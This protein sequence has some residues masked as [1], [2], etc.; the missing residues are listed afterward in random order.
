MPASSVF[1]VCVLAVS[2]SPGSAGAGEKVTV[3]L[4]CTLSG[5]HARGSSICPGPGRG[6]SANTPDTSNMSDGSGT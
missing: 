6:T 4:D 2:I 5:Y 1:R 3:G